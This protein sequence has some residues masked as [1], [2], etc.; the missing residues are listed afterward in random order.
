MKSKLLIVTTF[1]NEKKRLQFTL[2]NM[3]KQNLMDFVHLII[4]DGS[5]D[6]SADEIVQDYIIRS[7]H[8]VVFEKH[9]NAGIN[10]VHML[11][12]MRTLEFNCSHFMWLDC[13]DS[14]KVNAVSIINKIINKSPETWLHLDGYYV[15]NRGNKKTRMSSRGY[16]PYLKKA[17]QFIPFCL[18]VSTYGHFIIPFK[19]YENINPKFEL[20]DGFYY[21][22][23]I[24]GSLSLNSCPHYFVKKPLS[25]I[26]DDQHFSVTNSSA[27]SYRKNL[28][29]LSEFI[30]SD[31]DKRECISNKSS[32]INDISIRRLINS[33]NF[34]VNRS[35]IIALKRFYKSNGI[36]I[37]DRY[38]WFALFIISILHFC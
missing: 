8:Q 22:A 14:L 23:Q 33:K 36:K 5:T 12:F 18:S 3:L 37:C 28:L 32:G 2:D 6:N 16:L 35:K 15:S 13:G 4:D 1:Y 19:V 27:N 34:L 11:A 31:L 26:E 30:V 24:V 7:K 10:R 25:I 21:D 9:D 29:I 20:V 38:K 17:D